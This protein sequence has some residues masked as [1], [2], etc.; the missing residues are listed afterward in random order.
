MSRRSSIGWITALLLMGLMAHD[1]RGQT[2]PTSNTNAANKGTRAELDA[3]VDRLGKTQPDWFKSTSLNYPQTLNLTWPMRPTGGWDNQKNVGQFLWDVVNPNPGRWKEGVKLMHHLLTLHKDD[4]EKRER[5]L[6]TLAHMYHNLLEDY[7]R[8][9]FWYRAAGVEKDPVEFA[10]SAVILAECYWRLGFDDEARKLLDKVPAN[11]SRAKLLGDMGE[12][13]KA[14]AMALADEDS[15]GYL[16]RIWP[17][18]LRKNLVTAP[19]K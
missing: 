3:L 12:T 17:T 15:Q 4:L 19:H 10:Q 2:R 8:S 5:N 18:C 1:A 7:G 6:L 14:I 16:L 13:D 9:A 11:I